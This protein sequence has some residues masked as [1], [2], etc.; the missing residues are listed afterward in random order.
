VRLRELLN[1]NFR[2]FCNVAVVG[3]LVRDFAREGRSGFRSDVDLVVDAPDGELEELA[4]KLGARR[5]KF[6][7]FSAY[8]KPWKLD[9]WALEATWAARSGHVQV[10][11]L[12]DVLQC[13]FFNWDAALYSLHTR[14][15][16][17][18][19][20]YLAAIHKHEI[21]IN[22]LPNPSVLGN[23]LR[24][25]RR[26]L[27]WDLQAGPRLKTFI[28]GN[29]TT[30]CFIAIKDKE[31]ALH[32]NPVME[33]FP[34]LKTLKRHLFEHQHRSGAY[35]SKCQL[36]LALET[37]GDTLSAEKSPRFGRS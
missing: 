30:E 31:R 37:A 13:T 8:C 15:V 35:S 2:G 32:I 28:I 26:L 34:D 29:L 9:F 27:L 3:G 1:D 22:L 5:N 36:S 16:I 6:G 14:R 4:G 11:Q 25:V 12:E 19:A 23:L 17:C 20:N 21:D 33:R 24:A 18:S 7:G 10:R